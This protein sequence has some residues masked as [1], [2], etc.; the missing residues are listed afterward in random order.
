MKKLILKEGWASCSA[1]LAAEF[2]LRVWEL[3][4]MLDKYDDNDVV[5]L[6]LD[7]PGATYVGIAA[8]PYEDGA[9]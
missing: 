6:K 3:K 4:D 7:G 2:T 5:M 9:E 1:D 8:E